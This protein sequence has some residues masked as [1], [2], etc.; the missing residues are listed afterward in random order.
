MNGTEEQRLTPQEETKFLTLNSSLF[1]SHSSVVSLV[2]LLSVLVC[3]QFPCIALGMA[4][5]DVF[6]PHN[7]RVCFCQG[8]H[9]PLCI[10]NCTKYIFMSWH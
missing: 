10:D 9:K 5:S 2:L 4:G 7:E 6:I 8:A 1:C 3:S